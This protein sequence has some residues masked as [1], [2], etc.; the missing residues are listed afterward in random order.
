[1]I[2]SP[3]FVVR[4]YAP[5]DR[6]AV[7]D[8]CWR[9]GYLGQPIG[10]QWPDADSFAELFSGWYTDHEPASA[11]VV[12]VDGRVAGYLLGCRDTRRVPDLTRRTAVVARRRGLLVRPGTRRVLARSAVDAGRD[13][14]G[15]GGIDDLELMTRWPA[16]LHID[17]LPEAR[18]L[19]AG[20][21]LLTRWLDRLDADNV[22][23]CH[24]TTMAENTGAVAFFAAHGFTPLGATTRLPGLRTLEG[25]RL[26]RLVMVRAPQSRLP[27]GHVTTN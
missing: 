5:D 12:E 14:A 11:S 20:H 22:P 8:I 1:M 23:G 26:H 9:T 18:G 13:R 15:H 27:I 25:G 19:G 10:W 17:L 2:E 4:A 7:R 21:A 24:L 3:A 16:H 6:A